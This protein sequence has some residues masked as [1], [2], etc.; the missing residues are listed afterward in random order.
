MQVTSDEDGSGQPTKD[1]ACC[2][3]Y[4]SIL[5]SRSV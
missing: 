4:A 1:S 2:S 3:G 5:R